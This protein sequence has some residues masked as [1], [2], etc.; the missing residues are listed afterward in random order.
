ME[1]KVFTTPIL[2]HYKSKIDGVIKV[3]YKD[4]IKFNICKISYEEFYDGRYQYI[5][6]PYY[7]VLDALSPHM[8]QGI[9]GLNLD[10]RK[11]IYY[12]VNKIPS[13]ISERTMREDREN[14]KEELDKVCM[15]EYNPLEWLIRT[16]S[17]Y[18]GDNLIVER[19]RMPKKISKVNQNDLMYGDIFENL[20]WLDEDVHI[21]ANQLLWL[22]GSGVDI[23]DKRLKINHKNRAG[24]LKV[25]IHQY[26]LA[27]KKIKEVELEEEVKE[28]QTHKKGRGKTE[29]DDFI[30]EEVIKELELKIINVSEAMKIMNVRSKS[31]MQRRIREYKQNK[32]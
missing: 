24:A 30:M 10:K 22:I 2:E 32:R 4:N 31:T 13:F 29:I 3:K 25:L 5:F 17:E 16:D 28:E 20:E 27:N 14:L 23:E 11:K 12:R 1:N 9:P 8:S 7:D 6:E 18:S 19:Y 26:D 15:G 21:H